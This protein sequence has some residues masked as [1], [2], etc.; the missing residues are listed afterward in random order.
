[1]E[2]FTGEEM[3]KKLEELEKVKRN[4]EYSEKEI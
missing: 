1:M 4:R 3:V 2:K